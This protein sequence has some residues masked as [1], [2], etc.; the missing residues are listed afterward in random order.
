MPYLKSVD[1][2]NKK[3]EEYQEKRKQ[4]NFNKK[5]WIY[6]NIYNTTSW[7]KLRKSYLSEHPLCEIC[8]EKG[9]SVMA[10][11]V[12]HKTEISSGQDEEEMKRLG[13]DYN[14]LQSLCRTCHKAI[15]DK[16]N[17][18]KYFLFEEDE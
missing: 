17:N 15:H 12:H 16:D 3:R 8:L 5:S 1:D 6:N 11:N 13:F 9:K 10:E 7:R 4:R 2:S 18:D 14:N